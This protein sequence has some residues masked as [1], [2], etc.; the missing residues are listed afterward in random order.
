LNQGMADEV[1]DF[2]GH[3]IGVRSGLLE[4][5]KVI[6]LLI[7]VEPSK[8]RDDASLSISPRIA[9]QAS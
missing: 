7:I 4:I 5:G 3:V 1:Y 2:G 8:R 9:A 6:D